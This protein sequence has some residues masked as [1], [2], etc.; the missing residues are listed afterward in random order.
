MGFSINSDNNFASIGIN[1]AQ[2]SQNSALQKLASMH[3][4]NSAKD[5][6]A[7]SAIMQLQTA[8]IRGTSQ[9]IRNTNDGVSLV[10]TAQAG[11]GEVTSN[12]QR[13]RELAV[14]AANG[15]NSAGDRHAL[16]SE[17]NQL[18]QANADITGNSSFNGQQLFPS[19]SESVSF[20]VGANATASD[21][22]SVNLNSLDNLNSIPGGEGEAIDVSQTDSAQTAIELIDADL[23]EV[24]QQASS[25]G[26]TENRFHASI[27]N[28]ESYSINT[29]ASR[30]R[31]ADTD[32]AKQI[33]NLI[34]S[35]ILEQSSMAM[36][37]HSKQSKQMVLSL[38]GG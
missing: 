1:N 3:R 18:S 20:Q 37:G 35:Q 14:Q 13:M 9:A 27:S 8:Q 28:S 2:K 25:L 15:S 29:Q 26:A 34:Q 6:A 7:G 23:A 31:I 21:Q 38:L 22:I 5:D 36:A 33:S 10:Q 16:Q 19:E 17:M 30:S 32:A 11:L 24:S 12:L 4:I